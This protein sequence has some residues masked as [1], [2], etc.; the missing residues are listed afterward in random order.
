VNQ[1]TLDGLDFK[2]THQTFSTRYTR[3]AEPDETLVKIYLH[4]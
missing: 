2:D 3:W 4:L 1:A